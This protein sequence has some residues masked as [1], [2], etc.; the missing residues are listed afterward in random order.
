MPHPSL[1]SATAVEFQPSGIRDDFP[2]LDPQRWRIETEQPNDSRV[3][4]ES[5]RLIMDTR[6]GMTVWLQQRLAGAY[7]IEFLR[8]VLVA[9]QANDRLSDMNIFWAAHDPGEPGLHSRDGVLESYDSMAAYYVGM[10]GN[11]NTTTR[12]RY[13]DGSGNRLLLGE[14]LDAAH[15]LEVGRIYRIRIDVSSKSTAY[16]VDGEPVFEQRL[17]GPPAPGYFGFRSVW[18]RQAISRF[19]VQAL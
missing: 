5:S 2:A 7:R 10:G 16:W 4:V 15:L 6:A 18:S 17:D 3:F 9:G 19:S 12:F 14:R 1:L 11:T 8:Q 13:Y